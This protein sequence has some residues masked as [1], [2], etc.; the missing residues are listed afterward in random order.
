MDSYGNYHTSILIWLGLI[1][2][3]CLNGYEY[4]VS[5]QMRI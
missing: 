2:V 1:F 5:I 3:K 4:S